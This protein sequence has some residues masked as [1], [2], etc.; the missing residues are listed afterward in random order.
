MK[1]VVIYAL[2][3]CPWCRKAKKYFRE[4]E[5]PFESTDY[6]KADKDT[7]QAIKQDCKAHGEE[8]SFPFVKIDDD[9]VVGY[10]PDKYKKL[11][12]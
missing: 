5:I 4:L 12:K 2:S 9:V 10:A 11:L 8:M 3:T 6:D 1:K 7:Q